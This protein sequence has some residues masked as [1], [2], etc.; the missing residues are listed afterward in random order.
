MI[1]Q[2]ID[3]LIPQY[4][5]LV[6]CALRNPDTGEV[7]KIVTGHYWF[8]TAFGRYV[9]IADEDCVP[10][11]CN[12]SDLQVKSRPDPRLLPDIMPEWATVS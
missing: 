9:F 12:A 6:L 2:S 3:I 10:H 4:G 7:D 11:M 5:D 8:K 1:P